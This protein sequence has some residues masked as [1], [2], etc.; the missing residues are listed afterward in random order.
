MG[1]YDRDY[2]QHRPAGYGPR[3]P[4]IFPRL[5]SGVRAFLIINVAV[6]LLTAIITPLGSFAFEWFSVF[7]YNVWMSIQPWRIVTY[8]FLHDPSSISH[9]LF[10]MI[11][12]YFF[13][14]LLEN[15]WGTRRFI[16]FYLICGA[17]G[18]IVYPILA[19][20]G[21]LP[22][23]PL[24]GASG[25]IL[26]MLAAGAILFP[27]LRV[28]I[29]GI[30]PLRLS[31][32]AV[33]LAVVSFLGLVRGQNAGGEAAHLAGMAA[34]AVYVLTAAWRHRVLFNVK[35]KRRQSTYQ[36][37]ETLEREVD[38]I[39][40]KVHDSGIASLS[41]K[42]KKILKKATEAEQMRNTTF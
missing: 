23:G 8:Q 15:F 11:A 36:S 16:V 18:G 26:G 39:L 9:I 4:R 29:W 41:H 35:M 31:V 10:N 24:V 3:M 32:L 7:P 21:V 5:T 42:E 28:Y 38:R 37:V 33:I 17:M 27:N 40:K 14:P 25:A 2:T 13:G 30:L 12:L 22:V 6:Y 34:G 1:L 19:L 20:T